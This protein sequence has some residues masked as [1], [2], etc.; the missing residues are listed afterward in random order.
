MTE[1]RVDTILPTYEI[2]YVNNGL[3]HEIVNSG[4]TVT[5]TAEFS[6]A[7][8]VGNVPQIALTGAATNLAVIDMVRTDEDT[9]YYDWTVGT[10]NGVMTPTVTVGTD[11]ASNLIT[12]TGST[13]TEITVDNIVP[14]LDSIILGSY[15]FNVA[16]DSTTVTLTFSEAVSTFAA[17][18]I[19]SPNG[20]ISAF[21]V[22]GNPLIYTATLTAN[23]I[24]DSDNVITVGTSWTDL[25]GNETSEV[26]LIK[27]GDNA[28]PTLITAT[29]PANLASLS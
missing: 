9:Y 28:A 22:T 21:T 19:T 23:T 27:V 25:A 1:F 5:I 29:P 26:R 2:S 4:D 11:L 24:E 20:V 17:E 6:E 3:S 10:G 13:Q 16:T 12:D 18:D 14:T 7:M 15:A 8:L